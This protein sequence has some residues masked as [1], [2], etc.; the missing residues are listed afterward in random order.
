MSELKYNLESLVNTLYDELD[1]LMSDKKQIVLSKPI[2]NILNKRTIVSNIEDLAKEVKR[3]YSDI[4]DYF[5]K[6]LN[7]SISQTGEGH[8]VIVGIVK[9]Q[10]IEKHFK[11]YLIANVQCKMCKSIDTYEKK[12]DRITYLCCNKCKATRSMK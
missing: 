12:E 6:E 3:N 1:E 5:S 9:Q 11:N 8:M 7:M 10:F 4:Q 2:V